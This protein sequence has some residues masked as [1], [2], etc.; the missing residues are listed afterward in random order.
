MKRGARNGV[1]HYRLAPLHSFSESACD[2]PD[3]NATIKVDFDD[4]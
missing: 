3:A 4:Y 1:V 2:T